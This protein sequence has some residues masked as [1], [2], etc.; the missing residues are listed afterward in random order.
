MTIQDLTSA[1]MALVEAQKVLSEATDEV[2]QAQKAATEGM[3]LFI[4]M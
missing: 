4:V 3:K 1:A 2:V